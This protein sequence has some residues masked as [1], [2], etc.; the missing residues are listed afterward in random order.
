MRPDPGPIP[1]ED[2]RANGVLL[3]INRRVLHPVGLALTIESPSGKMWVERMDRSGAAGVIYGSDFPGI[4]VKAAAFRA[5]E[6]VEHPPRYAALGFLVEPLPGDPPRVVRAATCDTEALWPEVVRMAHD[7]VRELPL[8]NEILQTVADCI[9]G[10]LPRAVVA[11]LLGR[12]ALVSTD[13]GA[14]WQYRL[15][16]PPAEFE[17]GPTMARCAFLLAEIDRL[18]GGGESPVTQA[19]SETGLRTSREIREYIVT[20]KGEL[21]D[22][23][24]EEFQA[25]RVRFEVLCGR[26]VSEDTAP[27]FEGDV[28]DVHRTLERLYA[29]AQPGMRVYR[30]D[31]AAREAFNGHREA[32][33][34][35]ANS[36]VQ[37]MGERERLDAGEL[38]DFEGADWPALQ[39]SL[40]V[41]HAEAVDACAE[42]ERQLNGAIQAR[43]AAQRGLAVC[44]RA[45]ARGVE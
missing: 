14:S 21:Y 27:A 38:H 16:D 1:L 23:E 20:P 40:A 25:A 29:S 12:L 7:L 41:E 5:L 43:E 15:S 30:G 18:Q 17:D 2:I 24:V 45:L 32:L 8:D 39:A 34:D 19:E 3:E 35:A 37:R 28:A 4:D 31:D 36:A 42:L 44:L 13:G 26:T 22:S 11:P 6:S 10:A 33:R 9:A